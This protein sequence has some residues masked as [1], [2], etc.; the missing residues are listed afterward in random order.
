[1]LNFNED[2]TMFINKFSKEVQDTFV[3]MFRTK[4]GYN[5]FIPMNKAYNEYIRDPFHT[6]LN[7]TRWASLTEFAHDLEKQGIVEVTKEV[8]MTGTE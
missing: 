7:S 8:D 3:E 2:P 5:G 6:H 1:M 4:Y